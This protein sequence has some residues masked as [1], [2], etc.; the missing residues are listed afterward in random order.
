VT[1]QVHPRAAQQELVARMATL[2]RERFAPR[3]AQYDEAA[4]Y[5]RENVDDLFA[6]SLHAPCIPREHGGLGL[7]PYRGDV[8]TLWSMTR[9]IARVDLSFARCWEGHANSLVILDGLANEEQKRRWFADVV[10][11]GQTWV[12]WS[13]EPQSRALGEKARF[14]TSIER[15][16]GGWMLEGTKAFCT[17]AGGADWA[18][19]LVNTAGPGGA[20]HASAA[21]ENL[22]LLGVD[23]SDPSITTDGSWWNPI[24]MRST[25]SHAVHF[26]GT[27]IPHTNVIGQPGQ[28]LTEGWQTCFAPHYAA[29]FLGAAEGALDYVLDYVRCQNRQGD[30]YVQHHVGLMAINVESGLLWLR[31]VARLWE[32]EQYAEAQLAGSRARYL[33]EH[34]AEE[35]F[36]HA[37][38]TCGARSLNRPSALERAWRDLS[39][40]MRHDNDDQ[41]LATVG[42]SILGQSCDLSFYKP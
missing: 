17:S 34:L 16:P 24:G 13:G 22:L 12:A 6:A 7:G 9:E 42:R 20:R 28:Y 10:E 35:T 23:L 11:R 8:F 39:I 27:F 36:Q 19:L 4:T 5:P 26:N 37:I 25:V 31:N 21:P 14:G 15:V 3:A 41:V 29:S 40:Y 2:A 1:V 38:R 18:I 33:V 32:E 30:P